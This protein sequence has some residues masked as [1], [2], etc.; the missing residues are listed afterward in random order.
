MRLQ[1]VLAVSL[2]VGGLSLPACE[3]ASS[4]TI[5][6]S[7]AKNLE[8][9]LSGQLD[10]IDSAAP[11]NA[12]AA[13]RSDSGPQLMKLRKARTM[14]KEL[15]AAVRRISPEIH[16]VAPLDMTPA[17]RMVAMEDLVKGATDGIAQK[18]G[19][20][21]FILALKMLNDVT[22]KEKDKQLANHLREISALIGAGEGTDPDM[23][24]E[25]DEISVAEAK[26]LMRGVRD[27]LNEQSAKLLLQTAATESKRVRVLNRLLKK[28]LMK[29]N[30]HELEDAI[31][32]AS[33]AYQKS[34]DS[35]LAALMHDVAALLSVAPGD[36]A[37]EVA[38]EDNEELDSLIVEDDEF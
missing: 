30:F 1:R 15:R 16:K 33:A 32:S 37:G 29:H 22:A 2:L 12:D 6:E 3:P 10:E 31:E 5:R 4:T 9:K 24:H 11:K 34:E 17:E 38:V 7:F 8:A 35:T 19:F 18:H 26:V 28:L 23:F 25:V 27:L 20:S 36:T 13:Q 21:D 14:A